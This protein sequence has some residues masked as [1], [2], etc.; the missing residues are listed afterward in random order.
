MKLL[1]L[2]PQINGEGG[3]QKVLSLKTSWL[4]N[5][6]YEI[7]V[8]TQYDGHRNPFFDFHPDLKVYDIP[9]AG[10][11]FN[12]ILAYKKALH[13]YINQIKPDIIIVCDFGL[14]A[15]LLPFLLKRTVPIVFEAHGSVYNEAVNFKRNW[16]SVFFRNCKYAFR[17]LAARHFDYFVVL[18]PASLSEWNKVNG[19]I[20]PNPIE[21]EKFFKSP[22]NSTKI[23]T[24]ARHSYEKGLDRM[25]E[26]WKKVGAQNPNW[27]WHIYGSSNGTFDFKT[28]VRE[29]GMQNIVLHEPVISIAHVYAKA[30][31]YVMTSRSEGFPVVLL[32]SMATGVPVIAYDCPVGPRALIQHESNG[33]LIP[34]GD[35]EGF[36]MALQQL[37]ENSDL[38]VKMG[39][40]ALLSVQQYRLDK[41][42]P[43]WVRLFSQIT[44]KA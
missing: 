23:I 28:M 2:T 9:L 11:K 3:V 5:A 32:E 15:F 6:G 10:T 16:L 31:I 1:Y 19:Y 38:R 20:I 39:K 17:K 30:S 27:Q 43:Q 25:L 14:K 7:T 40:E 24:V 12:K 26:I 37:I 41:V 22:L 34:D 35:S 36:A 29:S 4:I 42:M 44:Q 13:H 33:F 21:T 8:L 18:S